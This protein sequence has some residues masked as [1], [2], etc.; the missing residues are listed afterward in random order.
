MKYVRVQASPAGD[1]LGVAV[2]ALTSLNDL[3]TGEEPPLKSAPEPVKTQTVKTV[4]ELKVLV[5]LLK[6]QINPK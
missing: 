6:D 2:T 4:N 5:D 3:I 1:A